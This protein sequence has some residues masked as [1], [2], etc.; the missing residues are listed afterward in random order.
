MD[1]IKSIPVSQ[2]VTYLTALG[3][4]AAAL[5]G[6]FDGLHHDVQVALAVVIPLG[7][8]AVICTWLKGRAI[9]VTAEK[10]IEAQK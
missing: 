10:Q 7:I 2:V 3:P 4:V 8:V 1:N 5:L 6:A 9:Y